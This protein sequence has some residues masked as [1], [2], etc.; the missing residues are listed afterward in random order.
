MES[1]RQFG[2]WKATG[3]QAQDVWTHQEFVV[4]FLC[5][6]PA[7]L[8]MPPPSRHPSSLTPRRTTPPRTASRPSFGFCLCFSLLH[9][10]ADAPWCGV[11]PPPG[12]LASL[13]FACPQARPCLS[14]ISRGRTA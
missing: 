5:G 10:G 7:R 14:G 11:R 3:I 13:S 2:D 12:A 6:D 1:G 9:L 8:S 4:S